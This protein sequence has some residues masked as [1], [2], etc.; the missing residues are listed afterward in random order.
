MLNRRPVTRL[1]LFLCRLLLG[2]GA[3]KLRGKGCE[4]SLSHALPCAG[5]V[6]RC[7]R[8]RERREREHGGLALCTQGTN[9][10]PHRKAARG[11]GS[12]SEDKVAPRESKAAEDG[13]QLLT[14]VSLVT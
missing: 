7:V 2:E 1:R 12:P 3:C 10:L 11:T 6:V 13:G 9:A 8:G 5:V 4:H 14:S